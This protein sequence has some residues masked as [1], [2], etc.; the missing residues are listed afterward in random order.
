MIAPVDLAALLFYWQ[1]LAVR[2]HS[3]GGPD[4]GQPALL[5]HVSSP[6]APVEI[7]LTSASCLYRAAVSIVQ[8]P[9]RPFGAPPTL[10]LVSHV[11]AEEQPVAR[12][13]SWPC[14]AKA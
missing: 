8:R 4:G 2:D 12:R 3:S 10:R 6:Q 13:A 9:T 14:R 7:R 1:G 5:P 11:A